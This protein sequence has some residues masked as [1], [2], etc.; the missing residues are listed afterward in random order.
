[1]PTQQNVGMTKYGH[2]KLWTQQNVDTTKCGHNK[3]WTRQNVDYSTK[4]QPHLA[5]LFYY[6]ISPFHCRLIDWQVLLP[7][8]T[9]KKFDNIS[10]A[11]YAFGNL[12]FD[13]ISQYPNRMLV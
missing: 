5:I 13:E 3:M 2:D 10:F 8:P 1:M 6:Y 4:S 9:L 12:N 11:I 7:N